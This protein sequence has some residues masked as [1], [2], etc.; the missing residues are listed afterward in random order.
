M[1]N[2]FIN[3]KYSHWYNTIISSAKS[4][5]ASD[6]VEKHHI[7]PKSLGGSNDKSNLVNLTPKEHF[8][9]H[10]LLTRM[11]EGD[12]RRKMCYAFWIMSN[13]K[14]H[15]PSS[16]AYAEAKMLMQEQMKTRTITE[17]FREKCRARLTGKQMYTTTRTALLRANTGR[18]KTST[19][20]EKIKI[21]IDEYYKTNINPRVGQ[22]RTEEQ[23][24]RMREAKKLSWGRNPLQ[25]TTGKKISRTSE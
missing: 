12:A 3:N 1:P 16:I 17:E 4:R 11:T 25:G 8:V 7:I 24:A 19:E 13:R 5:S 15:S 14:I 10:R 2:I 9:C 18:T 6:Y 23:K 20:K 22:K 21:S